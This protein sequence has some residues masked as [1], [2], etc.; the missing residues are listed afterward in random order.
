MQARAEIDAGNLDRA[1]SLLTDARA[2][3]SSNADLASA[4]S[5]LQ[6]A[7]DAIVAARQRAEAEAR[8][9]AERQATQARLEAERQA[10]LDALAAQQAAQQEAAAAEPEAPDADAASSEPPIASAGTTTEPA[11]AEPP[12]PVDVRDQRPVP[13]SSLTRTKYVAA[14]YPRAAQ[15]R[16]QFGWVDIVFTVAVDGSVKDIEVKGSSPPGVF[17]SAAVRAV[18][19]WTFEPSYEDGVVV[20][21]RAGSRLVFALE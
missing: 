13:A 15:R 8:A 7:R 3:D 20:E 14:K 18:E 21:K 6:G 19:K 4:E 17:D 1:G 9:E 5:A 10:A 16:G 12:A 2:I 11:V